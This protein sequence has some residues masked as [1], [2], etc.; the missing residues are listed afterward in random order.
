MSSHDHLQIQLSKFEQLMQMKSVPTN[1][2][3]LLK[4]QSNHYIL[5]RVGGLIWAFQTDQGQQQSQHLLL[6]CICH[7][8]LQQKL[9]H[10][11]KLKKENLIVLSKTSKVWLHK[12]ILS[13]G[14]KLL[15]ILMHDWMQEG[16]VVIPLF[17]TCQDFHLLF[18]EKYVLES[19]A[20]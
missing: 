15:E 10:G 2:N 4:S 12:C 1:F 18:W 14:R 13:I 20:V 7:S 6:S 11:H 9:S 3:W 8:H 16:Y 5:K 17:I 19:N